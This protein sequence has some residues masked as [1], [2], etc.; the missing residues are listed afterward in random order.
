MSV[1]KALAAV[2]VGSV[3]VAAAG[4][5]A[6]STDESKK[7]ADV[8]VDE[9][10]TGARSAVEATKKAGNEAIDASKDAARAT[11]DKTREIAGDV[12]EKSKDLALATGATVT[13]GWVTTKVRAK[14][15]DEAVLEHSNIS[16]ETTNH[17]VTLTGTVHSSTARSRAVA[18]AAGTEGVTRVVDQLVVKND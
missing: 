16:V 2:L 12:A 4:C 15:A 8:V 17:V 7:D 10:R 18:I 6:R 9:T 13:D 11:A 5:T 1:S 3:V 14:F